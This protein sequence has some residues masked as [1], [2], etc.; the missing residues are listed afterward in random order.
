MREKRGKI[1]FPEAFCR[2]P[3]EIFSPVKAYPVNR[4]GKKEMVAMMDM[5]LVS[6]FY[7]AMHQKILMPKLRLQKS[8]LILKELKI[9]IGILKNGILLSMMILKVFFQKYRKLL[10]S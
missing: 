9:L 3:R 5:F 4:R 10:I 2:K 1:S 6:W 8:K 7:N